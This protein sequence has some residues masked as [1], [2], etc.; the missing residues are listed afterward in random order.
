MQY[1]RKFRWY[2]VHP[3]GDGVFVKVK[4]RPCIEDSAACLNITIF[5]T[6]KSYAWLE[7]TQP[8]NFKLNLYDGCGGLLEV[9]EL[10]EASVQILEFNDSDYLSEYKNIVFEICYKNFKYENKIPETYATMNTNMNF[11]LGSS[12]QVTC[13]KCNHGFTI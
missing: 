9:W 2:L 4:T 12:R 6:N 11:G 13:P 5:E 3:N 8:T 1:S 7:D 10:L